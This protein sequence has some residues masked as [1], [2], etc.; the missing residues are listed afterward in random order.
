MW[1]LHVHFDNSR[2]ISEP[3]H[4]KPGR[5][6][7]ENLSKLA[8]IH[9]CAKLVAEVRAKTYTRALKLEAQTEDAVE[10]F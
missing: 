5:T 7:K 1:T 9:R 6:H 4:L 8:D 10:Y 2:T 3:L